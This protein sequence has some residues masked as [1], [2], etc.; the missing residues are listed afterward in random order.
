MSGFLSSRDLRPGYRSAMLSL[1]HRHIQT[2]RGCPAH[3][4][5]RFMPD[6]TAPSRACPEG[7]VTVISGKFVVV[8]RF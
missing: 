6:N 7:A 4:A 8:A 5:E 1:V 2:G 3:I